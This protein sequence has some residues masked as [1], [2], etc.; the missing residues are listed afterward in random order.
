VHLDIDMLIV[1]IFIVGHMD[2]SAN[3]PLDDNRDRAVENASL[4]RKDPKIQQR[5]GS[6]EEIGIIM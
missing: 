6:V 2:S 1:D 5:D 3:M 4:G